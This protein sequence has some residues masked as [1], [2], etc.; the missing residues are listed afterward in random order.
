VKFWL[1]PV[2]LVKNRGFADHELNR[3]EGLV[4]QYQGTD[5]FGT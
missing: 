4:V 1:D 2:T 3:I 5:Y